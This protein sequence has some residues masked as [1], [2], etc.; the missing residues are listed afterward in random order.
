MF[1]MYMQQVIPLTDQTVC[2][3]FVVDIHDFHSSRKNQIAFVEVV[4]LDTSDSWKI[5]EVYESGQYEGVLRVLSGKYT[6]ASVK[7]LFLLTNVT[8]TTKGMTMAEV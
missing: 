8:M 2:H 6:F 3:K 5:K 7:R 4:I 1:T